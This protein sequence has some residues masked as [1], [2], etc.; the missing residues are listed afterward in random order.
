MRGWPVVRGVPGGW[1]DPWSDDD[2][3]AVRVQ[4]EA[5]E[6]RLRLEHLETYL[7]GVFG[8]IGNAPEFVR[9]VGIAIGPEQREKALMSALSEVELLAA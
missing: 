2:T 5:E 8:F 3:T 6:R 4:V 9:A 1:R 7:R